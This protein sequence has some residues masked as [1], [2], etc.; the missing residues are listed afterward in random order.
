MLWGVGLLI[1][2]LVLGAIFMFVGSI[3]PGD[4]RTIIFALAG[5]CSLAAIVGIILCGITLLSGLNVATPKARN[6]VIH[7]DAKVIA[8]YAIDGQ[9]QSTFD[10]EYLDFD[11]PKLKFYVRLEL[12]GLGSAEYNCN[13]AV[14]SECGE[15]MR[16]TAYIQGN[17]VGQFIRTIGTGQGDIYQR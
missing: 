7:S 8:R 10:E 11:D 4:V 9:G 6:V 1:G 3:M 15:S 2:G 5:L 17:W 13:S 14:W 16:G 12:H